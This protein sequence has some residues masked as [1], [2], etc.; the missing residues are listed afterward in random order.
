MHP[1]HPLLLLPSSL[2]LCCDGGLVAVLR[3]GTRA[4]RGN[5]IARRLASKDWHASSERRFLSST[6]PYTAVKKR[7]QEEVKEAQDQQQQATNRKAL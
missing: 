3:P 4:A 6:E 5:R 2:P 1:A 7:N